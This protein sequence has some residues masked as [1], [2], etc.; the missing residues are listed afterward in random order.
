M[1][2]IYTKPELRELVRKGAT[3]SR[4]EVEV[5][6]AYFEGGDSFLEEDDEDCSTGSEE[7]GDDD[8]V[9]ELYSG[10]EDAF[11][12]EDEEEEEEYDEDEEMDDEDEKGDDEV[13][14]AVG[15]DIAQGD[16]A[17]PGKSHTRSQT[18][19]ANGGGNKTQ[20]AERHYADGDDNNDEP[21]GSTEDSVSLDW[22]LE[23]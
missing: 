4:A 14:G 5:L 20:R 15:Y 12:E 9:V 21:D 19:A 16:D 23:A 13:E 2:A 10:A 8:D 6:D 7:Y 18:V 22:D 3:I 11:H 17:A 1:P